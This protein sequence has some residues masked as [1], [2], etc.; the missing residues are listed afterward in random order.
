V[1][2][3]AK[4]SLQVTADDGDAEIATPRALR[5]SKSNDLITASYRLTLNEQRLILAAISGLDPRRPMPKRVVV[6]AT[7]YA[8]IYGVQLKHAYKQ[9]RTAADELYERDIDFSDSKHR[10]RRR[11]VDAAVYTEGA[12]ELSFTIHVIPYLTMLYNKVTTYDLRRVARVDSV[13]TLRLFEMLMQF[14]KT[15]WLHIDV[16]RLRSVLGLSDAYKRFNNLRQRV[17]DPAVEE[18]RQ[19]CGLDVTY[20]Q[21]TKGRTVTAIKFSFSDL[22]QMVLPLMPE[23][24][25]QRDT[26][27][28]EFD[29]KAFEAEWFTMEPI[30]DIEGEAESL[31]A[32][33]YLSGRES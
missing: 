29:P 28:P 32:E 22:A 15:G 21:I 3:L 33:E 6:H 26:E 20:E 9:M 1:K 5:I 2:A 24:D 17:I 8:E 7:D 11:W 16:D 4:K 13:S 25:D 23:S 30:G 14:R 10:S 19:K 31:A 18:M 12:V 27:L